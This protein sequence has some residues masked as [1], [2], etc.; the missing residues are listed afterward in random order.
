MEDPSA[1]AAVATFGLPILP[2]ILLLTAYSTTRNYLRLSSASKKEPTGTVGWGF[3]QA[4]CPKSSPHLARARPHP[5]SQVCCR[6][7]NAPLQ[8]HSE[9][10]RKSSPAQQ[11]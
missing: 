1:A 5:S 6:F 10:C 2:P 8:P 3:L 9:V 7:S 4:G 11:G